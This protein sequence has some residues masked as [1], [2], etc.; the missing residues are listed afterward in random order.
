MKP[1]NRSATAIASNQLPLARSAHTGH[2]APVPRTAALEVTRSGR[3]TV[4]LTLDTDA[5][6]TAR[7]RRGVAQMVGVAATE[8]DLAD[9]GLSFNLLRG[10]VE[11]GRGVRI[12]TMVRAHGEV[13]S[14][15]GGSEVF[16]RFRPHWEAV[17][18]M[19]F[20]SLL[21]LVGLV[22]LLVSLATRSGP[23]LW[24]LG[25]VALFGGI[26]AWRVRQL[27]TAR[28]ELES[29]LLTWLKR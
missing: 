12:R 3:R 22:A 4:I 10:P 16:V 15:A 9:V 19:T 18:W 5:E 8:V 29:D 21:A 17:G 20:T 6:V 24:P 1:P 13:R 25:T 14:L 26:T 11:Y 2:Y 27:S 28:R 7:I 23:L